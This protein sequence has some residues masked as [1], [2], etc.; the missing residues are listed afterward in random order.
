MSKGQSLQAL[1]AEQCPGPNDLIFVPGPSV[2]KWVSSCIPERFEEMIYMQNDGG[3]MEQMHVDPPTVR[4]VVAEDDNTA[5][6][7][8]ELREILIPKPHK[9]LFTDK[10]VWWRRPLRRRQQ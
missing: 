9:L 4:E 8:V 5:E 3:E 6:Q 2:P 7:G 1:V 10:L